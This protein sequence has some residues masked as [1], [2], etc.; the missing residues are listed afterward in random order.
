MVASGSGGSTID[1]WETRGEH[2][3]SFFL[4]R[5]RERE[6]ERERDW[7]GPFG[8]NVQREEGREGERERERASACWNFPSVLLHSGGWLSPPGRSHGR[9]VLLCAVETERER[10]RNKKARERKRGEGESMPKEDLETGAQT[11]RVAPRER[12]GR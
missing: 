2:L 10:E 3:P 9:L 11:S 4:G 5:E 8:D 7:G 6:R 12:V 1:R